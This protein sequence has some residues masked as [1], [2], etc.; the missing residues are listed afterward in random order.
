[1]RSLRDNKSLIIR[2]PNATRPW[3]HV[4]EPISGYLTLGHKLINNEI[5]ALKIKPNWNFGPEEINNITV[6][7]IVKKILH[8]WGS[9]K[10]IKVIK[11][12]KFKEAILNSHIPSSFHCGGRCNTK[13]K[14]DY[15]KTDV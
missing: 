5:N 4:L 6:I 12:K 9:K 10:K 15:M 13:T 11:N 1:M 7:E 2:N 14:I 8:Y 3:Q